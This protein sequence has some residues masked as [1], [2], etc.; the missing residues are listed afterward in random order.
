MSRY[1]VGPRDGR[2]PTSLP[3]ARERRRPEY[4]RRLQG[5]VNLRP[6]QW[7][8]T[9]ISVP[10]I[11]ALSPGARTNSL[12][13]GT[14]GPVGEPSSQASEQHDAGKNDE[15]LDRHSPLDGPGEQ[16]AVIAAS[17]RR[18]GLPSRRETRCSRRRLLRP[19]VVRR[20]FRL[21]RPA[22]PSPHGRRLLPTNT[23]AVPAARSRAPP[24]PPFRA[25]PD[26]ASALASFNFLI[27][28]LRCVSE[29]SHTWR[30]ALRWPFDSE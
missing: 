25:R 17:S 6:R 18:T 22:T 10:A 24:A 9:E 15:C 23:D 4:R 30:P 13:I 7:K 16:A 26:P 20:G 11:T 3:P 12:S 21:R 29:R 1:A 14:V 8:R 19:S 5:S 2:W 27:R 28:S